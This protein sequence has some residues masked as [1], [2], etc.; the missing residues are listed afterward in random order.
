MFKEIL[1]TATWKQSQ[2]TVAGTILNGIL[3]ALFYIFMARFLGPV[4]FGLLTVCVIIFTLIADITDLGTNTGLIRFVSSHLISDK[5]KA[6][7]FLKLGL[8]IKLAVWLLILCLGIFLAPVIASQ[9]LNKPILEM[10]LRLVF[11]GVGGALLFTFA[12]S[13][14]QSFQKYFLWSVINITSNALRLVLIFL[15]FYTQQL[16]LTS[17]LISYILLPFFGFFLALLFFPTR[18]IFLVKN[19][20]SVA[21]Q[22]FKFNTYVAIFTLIAAI[23]S[24]LD[25]FLTTRLLSAKDIGIYGAANQLTQVIPQIVAALGVVAAPKFSAFKNNRDMLIYFRKF[26][27]MVLGLSA[28]IL[29]TIPIAFYAIPILFGLDYSQ[30]VL[31]FVFLL[32]GMLVF[33]ISVPL[34]ISIIFYFGRSD[35]FVWVSIVHLL[36]I[37]FLGY[38]M[39]SN[40]GVIGTAIT[41]LVG[42]I[43]NFILPL[44]WFIKRLK[45]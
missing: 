15:L 44:F 28:L 5:E 6:F 29:L 25:T 39:I 21:K 22:F 36:I 9:V 18:Q 16:N 35:I 26:Q 43:S 17:G 31:P 23:S 34:H 4:N 2:I 41:V 1:K 30:S 33:L 20:F 45:K 8:E 19:E 10:P 40:F 37:G 24:R 38:F 27:L 32:L 13:A 3:G 42:M 12:T 11:F 7:K 14:L